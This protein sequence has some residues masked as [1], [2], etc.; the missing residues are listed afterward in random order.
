M[1]LN[2]MRNLVIDEEGFFVLEEKRIQDEE[3]G[4]ALLQSII[5]KERGTFTCFWD[6]EELTLE[7]FDEPL[8]V[9][10]TALLIEPLLP[11][12]E[13]SQTSSLTDI[14]IEIKASMLDP[15]SPPIGH[16]AVVTFPYGVRC[17]LDFSTLTVDPWDR[18]HGRTPQG[19]PYVFSR[20]AQIQL[21]DL[22][23]SFD[24]DSVS[25]NGQH[26]VIRP[27]LSP[28]V[29]T[30]SEGFWSELYRQSKDGWELQA[31][32]PALVDMLPR[33][34]LPRARVL[35]LGC[36]RGNDAA[37]FAESGHIVTAVDISSEAIKAGR[38]R[39]GHLTHIQWLQQDIFKI[40]ASWNGM[41]DMIFE[42]TCYCAIDPSQRDELVRIWNRLLAPQGQLMGVFFAMDRPAG[43]P[44][45]GTEWELRERLRK[46]YHFQFWGRW[47]K[48]TPNRQGSELFILGTR[49]S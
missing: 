41:Y 18:F 19:I 11:A 12:P 39:Y 29:E 13:T 25:F 3:I 15:H 44:F 26:Y 33:L 37:F 47:Q 2:P 43:P 48:S 35:V 1:M 46:F 38:E 10:S 17:A 32:A 21:F 7:P 27:W 49:R 14:P 23:D 20:R 8:V 40:P 36:G 22:L 4:A 24:D 34:K 28:N 6:D 5:R 30:R 31:P 45:G 9:Q 16:Q 42:H